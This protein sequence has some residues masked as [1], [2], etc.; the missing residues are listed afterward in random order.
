MGRLLC[1]STN[2]RMPSSP[3]R[4]SGILLIGLVAVA[5]TACSG[6]TNAPPAGEG[7]PTAAPAASQRVPVA[8]ADEQLLA[9]R[10]GGCH[11]PPAPSVL[12]KSDWKAA[13]LHMKTVVLK[14][15]GYTL[16]DPELD[17]LL[18]Y[19]Q[20]NSPARLEPPAP[21][22]A[23]SPIVFAPEP[24]GFVRPDYPPNFNEKG[25]GILN[26]NVV[27]LD[28]DGTPDVLVSEDIK[29]SVSWIHSDGATW[30]E[31]DLALSSTP[32]RT[33]I[34]D[35]DGDNDQDIAVAI[36]GSLI[37]T[38]QKV[39][40]AALLINDGSGTFITRMLLTRVGR[41][42]DVQPGDLDGDG[43]VDFAVAAFG[44]INTGEVGWIEQITP[45]R[46]A[47]HV[48]VPKPGAV[49]A[50]IVDLD[51]DGDLDIVAMISQDSEEIVA[52]L[53]DGK[54]TFA[55][56]VL[57][58]AGTPTF[59][60]SGM[61]LAD[62]DGDG[63]VDVVFTNGDAFD[64][65]GYG[66]RPY[67]GVH[68]LE[69]TGNLELTHHA[70]APFLGAYASAIGDL[71]G[72]GDLDIAAVSMFNDWG[73]KRRQ[74]LI[75]LENDGSQQ[76]TPHGLGNAPIHLVTVA[77]ADLDAD[78]RLDILTGGIHQLAPPLERDGRIT[79]WW[80]RGPT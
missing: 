51:A 69:N 56:N 26:L 47:Y 36:L 30:T 14:K 46:F 24:F 67:H 76:F 38:E 79:V 21:I 22:A 4:R 11:A 59:G 6:K 66:P 72:D 58:Q 60:A 13:L 2:D 28:R 39:G 41:V 80:N 31:E 52:L 40:G 15:T 5:A 49:R 57:F 19:Y 78:G 42:A 43:D 29:R 63:D 53:N 35:Y 45:D 33:V 16:T 75:W 34:F 17:A 7:E 44:F 48:I 9:L 23:D 65:G 12:S 1:G 74:S 77:L 18:A 8:P 64:T 25:P 73:D 62:L 27:D 3:H 55:P 68:W 54:G 71:D 61:E 10:C 32:S 70:L 37:P 20:A 50:P